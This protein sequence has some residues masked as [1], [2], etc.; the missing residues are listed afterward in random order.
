MAKK[1]LER[2]SNICMGAAAGILGIITVVILANIIGRIFNK[3]VS[4]TYEVVTYGIM[5]TVCLALSGTGFLKNHVSVDLISII[6][7]T[8]PRAALE[9]FQMLVSAATFVVV[10]ILLL[11]KLIPET[12][13]T[14][15]L[16][17]IFRIPY[18]LIYV[19][20]AI[21]M[22]LSALMFLYHA[23]LSALPL[24]GKGN[25]KQPQNQAGADGIDGTF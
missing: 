15:R 12:I 10:L 4:G 14:N 17:D 13:A 22:F 1:L 5:T 3:P 24:F 2:L 6:L 20:L 25:D 21:G 8:R 11:F 23:V 19:T 9:L 16:T 18:Y 7:P